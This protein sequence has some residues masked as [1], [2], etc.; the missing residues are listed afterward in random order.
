MRHGPICNAW[1]SLP[2][3]GRKNERQLQ[4]MGRNLGAGRLCGPIVVVRRNFYPRKFVRILS[5][6]SPAFFF[7]PPPLF[8]RFPFFLVLSRSRI[9]ERYFGGGGDFETD[10]KVEIE[11]LGG[12]KDGRRGNFLAFLDL[13]ATR[14]YVR[15]E[16][17]KNKC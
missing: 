5:V 17:M 16:G 15:R 8:L 7:S 6:V 1:P 12:K 10:R 14:Y 4:R 2:R 9:F 13:F 11:E 3:E